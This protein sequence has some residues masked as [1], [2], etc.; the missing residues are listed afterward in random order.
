[1]SLHADLSSVQ[2]TLDQVLDR[3]AEAAA[4]VRGTDR[5]DV[6]GD[7]YEVE[8]HL[9]AAVRRLSRTISGLPGTSDER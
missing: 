5:D 2:S 6:L 8:R 4:E 9:K 1:M 3:V 7:L